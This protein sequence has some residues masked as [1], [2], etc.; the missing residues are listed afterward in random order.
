MKPRAQKRKVL[1]LFFIF[2]I[3]FMPI[4]IQADTFLGETETGL[5]ELKDFTYPVYIFI[6][7]TLQP[8]RNYPLIISIPDQGE[9]PEKNV[10]L[11]T[12]I[13]KRQSMI[14]LV[15]TMKRIEDVPYDF[16]RWFFEMKTLVVHK[17]PVNQT[18]IFL[19][20]NKA[21]ATYAAYLGINYPEEFSAVGLLAGSWGGRYDKIL[22]FKSSPAQQLPFFVALKEDQEELFKQTEATATRLV[23]KGYPIKLVRFQKGEEFLNSDFKKELIAWLDEQSD[24]WRLVVEKTQKTLKE[25]ARRAVKNFFVV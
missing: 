1:V 18:K 17:Y 25:R 5:I 2:L 21:G 23:Q 10:E 12:S 13:A 24:K 11:W 9:A 16:D 4:R 15:P 6:P 19:V 14:V 3:G 8:E 20:G 22:Q 7:P